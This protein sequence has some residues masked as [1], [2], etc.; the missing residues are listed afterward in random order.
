MAIEK[1]KDYFGAL[2]RAGEILEFERSSAT[3]ELAAEAAGVEA[4]RIAKTL[5]FYSADGSGA[6]LVVTAGDTR[7]DNAKFRRLFGQ[8]ARMLRP[9]DVEPLTGHEIGG[10][11]PFANPEGTSVYLDR[12]LARFS[13][14]FP[15]AGSPSSAVELSPAE[16][17][18][19]SHASEWVDVCRPAQ[20]GA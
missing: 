9:E 8:K 12:S 4:A 17:F 5:A 14:V 6:L 7:I 19:L 11:C 16:L 1:V 3:V 13:T 2:G 10:V 15:A 18:A 20:Q